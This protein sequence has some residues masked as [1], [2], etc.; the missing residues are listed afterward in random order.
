MAPAESAVVPDVIE[1]LLR[2]Y[3]TR[4][5]EDAAAVRRFLAAHP[6]LLA[7]LVEAPTQI[8]D[9][10]ANGDR[11]GVEM[12]FDFEDEDDEGVLFVTVPTRGK[13]E[14]VEPWM[15]EFRRGWLLDASRRSH[16][17]FNVAPRY[18]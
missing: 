2:V 16:G 12:L 3:A 8:P 15:A 9:K 6:E 11:L 4:D 10:V 1:A 13:L 17:R 5:A 18:V 14:H 7:L